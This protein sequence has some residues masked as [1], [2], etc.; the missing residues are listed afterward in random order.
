MVVHPARVLFLALSAFLAGLSPAVPGFPAGLEDRAY[1]TA[2]PSIRF[3]GLKEGLPNSTVYPIAKDALGR[4]WVGTQD[5]AAVFNGQ[6]WRT[7][8]MPAESAS[9][10]VR[11]LQP[12]TDGSVWFGTQDGG[13]WRLHDGNW[14]AI[15]EAQGLPSNRI[16]SILERTSD[17]G[18]RQ[19]WVGT[20]KGL[21]CFESGSW[22][23]YDEASGILPHDWVWRVV[24]TRAVDG[25]RT[26]W[27]ATKGGFARLEG[28][29]WDRLRPV[30]GLPGSDCTDI[31]EVPGPAG[32]RTY[33]AALWGKG[34][35]YFNGRH[36]QLLDLK[37]GLPSLFIVS[38]TVSPGPRIWACTY[39]AGL[40]WLEE[41]TWHRL[42]DR[43]GLPASGVHF[44]FPNPSGWPDLWISTRGAGLGILDLGGW[45]SVDR[46]MGLPASEVTSI[47][48][49][50]RS[51]FWLGTTQGLARLGPNGWEREILGTASRQPFI[52]SLLE[53]HEGESASLWVGTLDGLA[54]QEHGGW[55]WLGLKDGLPDV[56]V[57]SLSRTLEEDGTPVIWVGTQGGLGRYRRGQWDRITSPEGLP[58]DWVYN[59]LQTTGHGG[60]RLLFVAT[61]GMGV[62]CQSEGRWIQPGSGLDHTNLS[63]NHLRELT[64][65]DG[66]RWLFAASIGK[67]LLRLSLDEAAPEWKVYLPSNL[68]GMPSAVVFRIEEGGDGHVYLSTSKGV[69]RFR[70]GDT[71]EPAEMEDFTTGDGL[72]SLSCNLGASFRDS[73]GRIWVGTLNGATV[74]APTLQKPLP[75]LPPPLIEQVRVPGEPRPILPG[76]ELPWRNNRLGFDLALPFHH[77]PEQTEFR[78]QLLDVESAPGPWSSSPRREFAALPQGNHT[79]RVWA[80]DFK[81]RSSGPLDFPFRVRPPWWLHP[82][83]VGGW[84]L[85]AVVLLSALVKVRT[86]LL[87]QRNLE[88]AARV[89]EATSALRA[90]QDNL[91]DLNRQ[92][93]ALDDQKNQF[94]RIATHDLKN[95]LNGIL[96]IS[97][98]LATEPLNPE[99]VRESGAAIRRTVLHMSQLLHKLLNLSALQSGRLQLTLEPVALR[100][101][102]ERVAA[103]WVERA[104]AKGIR[105]VVV[106]EEVSVRGDSIHLLEVVDNLVSNA[107]KFT[108]IGPP[109]RVIEIRTGR[110]QAMGFVSVKDEGPGFSAEDLPRAFG[111][112]ARLGARPTAGEIS[113]G[114]GLSIVK[115]MVESMEGRVELVSEQG[116]GALFTVH[117]AAEP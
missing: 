77:R 39:D 45:R 93:R 115:W 76:S 38:L 116:K 90:E 66:R 36:W 35:G 111:V 61:R 47:L 3:H 19:V 65:R 73:V 68:P 50:T 69:A 1:L 96:L 21:A 6:R 117:L 15:G 59:V 49:S 9:N 26:L 57:L 71:G 64:S 101:L 108:P 109:E 113:T 62:G 41:G 17:A 44:A 81:G 11:A 28:G 88:L 16:L 4:L 25:R 100:P 43:N 67:G 72:P 40:G 104:K 110:N 60:K 51:G 94:L 82:V 22:K 112:F 91:A 13:I 32:E 31:V 84:L 92:L 83:A 85:L 97:E 46:S 8:N 102:A 75:P 5:G 2:R 27:V 42:N 87:E 7:V 114:L 74:L 86:R 33:Y 55:R 10:F 99:E 70:L 30:E 12:M 20:V 48:G 58:H 23:T 79:L 18:R 24:E 34:I 95:P 53:V 54:R 105:L 56:H 37:S 52:S 63:V 80:R 103:D 29:H 89:E 98:A 106:S 107:V 14:S 78:T